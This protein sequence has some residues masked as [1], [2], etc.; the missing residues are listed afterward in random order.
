M[1]LRLW[2]LVFVCL[3]ASA[4]DSGVDLDSVDHKQIR[5][6]GAELLN[7][8]QQPVFDDIDLSRSPKIRALS[9]K[10]IYILNDGLYIHLGGLS[11]EEGLY[12]PRDSASVSTDKGTD[13]SYIE[14]SPG[15]FTYE[16]R[17]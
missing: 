9:P 5:T 4:C 1:I 11:V 17:G 2:I 7:L 3:F 15:L 6:E 8:Y 10:G 14:I 12:V 16:I 13:P